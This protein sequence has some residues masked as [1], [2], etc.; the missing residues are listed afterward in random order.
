LSVPVALYGVF[1]AILI[2]LLVVA[3]LSTIPPLFLLKRMLV[4][5]L[6][7]IGITVLSLFQKNGS[8]VF[9]ALCVRSTLC[10]F[11][12]VLFSNTTPFSD[13]LLILRRWGVPGLVITTLSLLYRYLFVFVDEVERME[14]ARTARTFVR[15]RWVLWRSYATLIGQLFVR[16]TE[17]AERIYAAM[18]A[19]GW[20]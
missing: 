7:V 3:Y 16:S 4:L 15:R 6:F 5:E 10:L 17:R 9:A 2:L 18:C 12:L 8:D 1:I 13:L 19:R 14:R 20:R 11:T